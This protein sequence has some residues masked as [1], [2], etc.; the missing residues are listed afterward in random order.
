MISVAKRWMVRWFDLALNRSAPTSDRERRSRSVVRGTATAI[1]ARAVGVFTGL[2]M[3]P[4]TVR[5][6]GTALYGAWMTISSVVVVFSFTDFGLAASLTNALGQAFGQNEQERARGY[7]STSL[8]ALSGIAV[9]ILIAALVFARPLAEIIFPTMA[10]DLRRREVVPALAL[11]LAIFAFNFP[12]ALTNRVLAAYQETAK[13]NLWIMAASLCSLVAVLIVIWRR[14]SL[15]LLVI[16]SSGTGLAVI[17][18]SSAWL[19]LWHKP[20]LRPRFRSFEPAFLRQLFST[21]WRFFL[22]GVGVMI[23][24]QTDNIVIAHFLGPAQVT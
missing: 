2:I 16:A 7:V 15:P 1:L 10:A 6:L 19:F 5:Y 3:V 17:A 9:I 8:L 14:G 18:I 12:L 20:W 22:I 11:A 24:S 4:L 13:A 21:G 23:N